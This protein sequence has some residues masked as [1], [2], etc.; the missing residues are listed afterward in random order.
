MVND[1]PTCS[2]LWFLRV[3]PL[4]FSQAEIAAAIEKL[5]KQW[6]GSDY[7]LQ[8]HSGLGGPVCEFDHGKHHGWLLKVGMM[9]WSGWRCCLAGCLVVEFSC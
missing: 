6:I 2:L 4:V 1:I 5:K 8:L 7:E 9:G 3:K